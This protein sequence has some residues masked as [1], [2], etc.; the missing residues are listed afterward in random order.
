VIVFS[1]VSSE[2]NTGPRTGFF[3][4][5]KARELL[6]KRYKPEDEEFQREPVSGDELERLRDNL[7]NL[8]SNLGSYPYGDWKKWVSLTNKISAQTIARYFYESVEIKKL[9]NRSLA[10]FS[11][12]PLKLLAKQLNF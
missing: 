7:K 1:A 8:D 6:A 5:F 9:S 2:G 3:H 4:D 12:K 10:H 11:M